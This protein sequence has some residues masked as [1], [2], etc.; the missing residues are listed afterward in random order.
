[1]T[2]TAFEPFPPGLFPVMLTPF[3]ADESAVDYEALRALA[4]WYLASG[5]A[6]LFPVAQ[7][8]EMYT[9]TPA[10]RLEC[11]RVVKQ[12]AGRAPVVA[13]GTFGKNVEECADFV[14]E[15]APLVDA[16]VVVVSMLATREESDEI[17][18]ARLRKLVELTPGVPLGLYECPAPYHRLLSDDMLRYVAESQ[19][20]LFLKDTCREN[21]VITRRLDMLKGIKSPFR[22]YNGNVTTMLHSLQAGGHGYGGVSANYYPWLHAFVCRHWQ[23]RV[24]FFFGG[25]GCLFVCL[26]VRLF[27]WCVSLFLR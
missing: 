6:G 18:F 21:S 27:F 9:L 13:C 14:K 11:A 12:E 4:R 8:S 2:G 19:R 20:F 24:S 5:A 26:Y 3:T 16:V 15:M 23:D 25:G 1:M 10:E 7:S 17:L 22:W